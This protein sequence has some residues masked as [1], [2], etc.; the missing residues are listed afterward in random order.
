MLNLKRFE[1]YSLHGRK[2]P[3]EPTAMNEDAFVA[4]HNL[5]AVIDGATQRLGKKIGEQTTGAYLA[6]FLH[7]NLTHIAQDPAYQG[8][9][10]ALLLA[11]INRAFGEKMMQE[12][13]EHMANGYH[14]GPIAAITLVRLH[15]DGTYS[16]AGAGDCALVEL[17]PHGEVFQCPEAEKPHHIEQERIDQL[18]ALKY[19]HG[20]DYDDAWLREDVMEKYNASRRALNVDWPAINGDPKLEELMF[21][22]RRSLDDVAALVLMSDGMFVPGAEEKEAAEMA[23]R[24]IV[25]HGISAYTTGLNKLYDEDPDRERFF[26]FKHQDD[27]TAVLLQFKDILKN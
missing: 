5:Y 15:D 4:A 1:C 22:G 20:I 6:E 7:R 11:G 14:F 26:R 12:H 19:E 2:T 23:A 9:E 25:Q 18:I 10:A 3:T 21:H 24:Q 16:Y 17:G 8:V 13:P 27:A